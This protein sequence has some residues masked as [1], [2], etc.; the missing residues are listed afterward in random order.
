VELDGWPGTT[1][2]NYGAE[3][4]ERWIWVHGIAF[5]E[6][7]G[8]WL[9]V[10][11]ARI[12]VAG[13]LL[14]WVANGALRLQDGTRIQIGGLGRRA[15]VRPRPDGLAAALRVADGWLDLEVDA[16]PAR[17]VTFAYADP[18]GGRGHEVRNCSIA[19]V[20]VRL[21]DRSLTTAHGGAYE[22]GVPAP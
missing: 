6:A 2:E 3:H 1:G 12:R 4:A 20:R 22:V 8:A 9:D 14:P 15:R 21:G 16:P 18:A 5:A 17:T 7:P 10:A 13:V 11:I 19:A